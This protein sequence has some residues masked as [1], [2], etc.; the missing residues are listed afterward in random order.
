MRILFDEC[1]P[2]PLRRL[3]T[4]HECRTAQHCGWT[5]KKNGEL[6]RLA[7]SEFELFLTADQNMEYQQRMTGRKIAILLLS[8]N[9][10]R[11]LQPAIQLIL[12]TISN[13]KPG[14]YRRLE[15][16]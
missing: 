13:M 11:R 12:D 2:A 4:G 14:E 15:I 3:F 5:E 8:T 9:R 6:L 10:L 16:P 7:E 1:I